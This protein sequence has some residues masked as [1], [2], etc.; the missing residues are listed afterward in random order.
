MSEICGLL[1]I[2]LWGRTGVVKAQEPVRVQ[3]LRPELAVERLDKGIVGR[4][5]WSREVQLDVALIGPQIE[6]AGDEL[7]ALIDPD[8]LRIAYGSAC[9]VQCGYDIL[10]PVAEARIDD[11]K[12]REKVSTTVRIR[13]L[14]PVA[15]LSW[16]KSI[17]QTWL[18]WVNGWPVVS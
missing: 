4:L 18:E 3:A 1:P 14:R 8:R 12:K 6:V 2:A 11:G 17:A 15:N 9:H 10:A 13:I 5:A 7:A 16:T